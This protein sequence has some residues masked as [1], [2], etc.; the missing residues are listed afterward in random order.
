[1]PDP[2]KAH[3]YRGAHWTFDPAALSVLITECKL[4]ITHTTIFAPTFDHAVKDPVENGISISPRHRILIFEGN[5]LALSTPEEWASVAKSF[6]HRWFVEVSEDVA[7]E[8]LA[9]R[10]LEAGI[11]KTY[12][13]GL[14]RAER[15]DLVNGRFIVANRL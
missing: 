15:N 2:E 11:C 7:R 12:E 14:D 1:M 10:H 6:D 9:K 3:F 5:Y 13:E 8:R 4:D